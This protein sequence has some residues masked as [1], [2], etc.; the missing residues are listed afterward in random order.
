[1]G[2]GIDIFNPYGLV[3]RAEFGTVL[4][5]TLYWSKNNLEW[6][7]WY[8]NHL[9]AINE[10]WVMNYITNPWMEEIRWYVMLMPMRTIQKID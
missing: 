4:S 3:T 2:V 7:N 8:K 6:S 9:A 10:I 5:R 1:M